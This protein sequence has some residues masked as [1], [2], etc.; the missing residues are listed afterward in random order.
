MGY[1]CDIC[2]TPFDMPFRRTSRD[3][4]DGHTMQTSEVLCPVC[5]SPDFGAA[6]TCPCG[7]AKHKEDILCRK[8]RKELL[9]KLNGFADFLSYEEEEQLDEWLDGESIRNRRNWT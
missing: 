7:N 2:G 6:D 8:C 1:I 5:G 3:V 4:I 9:Q